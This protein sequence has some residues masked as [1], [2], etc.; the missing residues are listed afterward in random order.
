MTDL[1]SRGLD[2]ALR[3]FR[4]P[5]LG[6]CLGMQLLLDFS[7][8]GDAECLGIVRG[9]VRRL[10]PGASCPHIGW[11]RLSTGG[12]AYFVHGYVC[13]P[14][15]PAVVTMTVQHGEKL[16]GLRFRNFFGVQWH[17]EKSGRT[18]DR[19]LATFAALCETPTAIGRND[20]S[21]TSPPAGGRMAD[22]AE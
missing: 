7:E 9:A 21:P 22:P 8:E 5:F 19:L 15:D 1:R 11:N 2:A 20:T 6:L 18:G 3:G 13:V 16:A 17:P 12:Y 14:D 10:P 4:K